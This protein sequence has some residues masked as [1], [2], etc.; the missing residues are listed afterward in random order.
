PIGKMTGNLGKYMKQWFDQKTKECLRRKLLQH[1]GCTRR[2]DHHR[3]LMCMSILFWSIRCTSS[4]AILSIAHS[5]NWWWS[6]K[7][8]RANV[9]PDIAPCFPDNLPHWE[10]CSKNY[11]DRFDIDGRACFCFGL[12]ILAQKEIGRAHV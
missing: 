12:V 1:L 10:Q 9:M 3:W 11:L 6:C 2:R 4:A 5:G 7:F 8:V